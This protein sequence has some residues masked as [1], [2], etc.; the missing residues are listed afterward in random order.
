MLVV[1]AAAN[2]G[3]Q[4]QDPALTIAAHQPSFVQGCSP[5]SNTRNTKKEIR[6]HKN[7]QIHVCQSIIVT[8]TPHQPLF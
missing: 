5:Y 7:T 2:Q 8:I 3:Q 6:K 1:A 4:D